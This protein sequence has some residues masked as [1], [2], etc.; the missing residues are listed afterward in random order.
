MTPA[1]R[2]QTQPDL[3]SAIPPVPYPG[4]APKEPSITGKKHLKA[5]PRLCKDDVEWVDTLDDTIQK[6]KMFHINKK[7]YDYA[8]LFR[9][10]LVWSVVLLVSSQNRPF[11]SMDRA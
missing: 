9:D 2:L 4:Q 7:A 5:Y 3:Q 6:I 11:R 10:T 1:G 8:C